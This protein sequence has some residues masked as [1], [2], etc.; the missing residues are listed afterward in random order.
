MAFYSASKLIIAARAVGYVE[1]LVGRS[2]SIF[3]TFCPDCNEKRVIR[4]RKAKRAAKGPKL[5][6]RCYGC[7]YK[8]PVKNPGKVIKAAAA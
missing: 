7:G 1:L 4:F 6:D 5:L 8:M 2:K 3:Q